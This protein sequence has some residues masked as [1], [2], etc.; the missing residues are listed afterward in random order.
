[1]GVWLVVMWHLPLWSNIFC[2]R[3]DAEGSTYPMQLLTRSAPATQTS[4]L[5][6]G[7]PGGSVAGG[8]GREFLRLFFP[9]RFLFPLQPW[10][11]D[12]GSPPYPHVALQR[13]QNG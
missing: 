8:G 4:P 6:T 1:M 10:S 2:P 7:S 3:R 9:S 11:M 13:D 5:H 12:A